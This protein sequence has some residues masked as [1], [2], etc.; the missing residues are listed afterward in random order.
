MC[1]PAIEDGLVDEGPAAAG[2]SLVGLNIA[3]EHGWA[4]PSIKGATAKAD[5]VADDKEGAV[6]Q[7]DTA[8]AESET[9]AEEKK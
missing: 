2:P 5:K 1:S 6:E 8:R 4:A 9:V 3:N 7:A